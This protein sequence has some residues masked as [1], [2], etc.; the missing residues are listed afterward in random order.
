MAE[1]TINLFNEFPQVSTAEWMAKIEAD[2]KGKDFE[3][4]L[5]WKTNEGFSVRPFYRS[6]DLENVS[7]LDSLPGQFPFVRGAKTNGN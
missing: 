6:E 3:K 7:Y 5:V 1:N 2:L 4:T